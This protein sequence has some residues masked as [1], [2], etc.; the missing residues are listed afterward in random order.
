MSEPINY[1][2]RSSIR[3][4]WDVW[5]AMFLRE[6][7][8]KT[9]NSRMGWFWMAFEPIAMICIILTL[10]HL[11]AGNR[12]IG[13]ADYIA[14]SFV[15]YMGFLLARDTFMN[16]PGAIDSNSGLFTYKQIKP[17]DTVIIR[18]FVEFTIK[19][20]VF[21]VMLV[22]AE[23]FQLHIMPYNPLLALYVWVSLWALGLGAGVL[24]SVAATLIP[25]VGRIIGLT[26]IPLLISSAVILPIN[27]VP[28]Q[29]QKILLLNPIV[30]GVETL[31]T[32]FFVDYH[33]VDGVSLLYLWIWA[34]SLLSLGLMFHVY[35]KEKLLSSIDKN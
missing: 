28:V 18:G 30:N 22:V 35:Y 5:S 11:V 12:H 9:T 19:S 17:V 25:E 15:G 10:R 27:Y 21:L 32:C 20:F 6:M 1:K 14:W 23:V 13:G 3:V 34:L 24:A 26:S 31:R 8:T 4:T 16:L 29:F 7:I 33:T 2:A